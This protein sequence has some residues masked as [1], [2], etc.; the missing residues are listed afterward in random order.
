MKRK[1]TKYPIKASTSVESSDYITFDVYEL[2]EAGDE[3]DSSLASFNT[4]DEAIDFAQ[5][6]GMLTHVVAVPTTDPD[7]DPEVAE[8]FEYNSEYEPYEVVWS[9]FDE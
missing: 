6:Q 4:L 5:E 9:N 8:W 7:D 1:F 2:D 3:V